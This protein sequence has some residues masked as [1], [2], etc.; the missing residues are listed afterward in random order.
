M[1]E[2]ESSQSARSNKNYRKFYVRNP[3]YDLALS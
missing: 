3:L 2:F 1:Q